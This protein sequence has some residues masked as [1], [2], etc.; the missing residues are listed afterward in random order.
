MGVWNIKTDCYFCSEFR[1]NTNIVNDGLC[2]TYLP[3][4]ILH[5]VGMDGYGAG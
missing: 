3:F 5:P 1:T 2:K 4:F